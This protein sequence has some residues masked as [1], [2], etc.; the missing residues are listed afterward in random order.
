MA[1]LTP[2]DV[3]RLLAAVV[4]LRR[5]GDALGGQWLRALSLQLETRSA[6]L[7]KADHG[8]VREAWSE[9]GRRRATL[10]AAHAGPLRPPALDVAA[11]AEPL[12]SV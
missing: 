8:L 11:D 3:A 9:M 5:D 10:G 12:P 7:S 2:G 6:L 1:E 4:R